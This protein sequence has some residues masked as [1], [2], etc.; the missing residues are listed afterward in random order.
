[1]YGLVVVKP[2]NTAYQ[3]WVLVWLIEVSIEHAVHDGVG[4]DRA[5]SGQVTASK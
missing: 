4:D 3:A 5:H 2:D 1:M